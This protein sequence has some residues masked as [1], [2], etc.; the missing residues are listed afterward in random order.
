MPE[1]AQSQRRDEN[2]YLR[3]ILPILAVVSRSRETKVREDRGVKDRD[4]V[5]EGYVFQWDLFKV[6]CGRI[7]VLPL[8]NKQSLSGVRV[9]TCTKAITQ[10]Y[11]MC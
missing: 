8:A 10:A 7:S 4:E 6:P 9:S 3:E 5:E 2:V 1:H 11:F